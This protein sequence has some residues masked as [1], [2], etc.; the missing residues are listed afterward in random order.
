MQISKINAKSLSW[1]QYTEI[2]DNSLTFEGVCALLRLEAMTPLTMERWVGWK[3]TQF[4]G[5]SVRR[6]FVEQNAEII[7]TF[8]PRTKRGKWW[9]GKC[10]I[11]KTICIWVNSI[12]IQS[13]TKPSLCRHGGVISVDYIS[14]SL[15]RWKKRV[16]TG[17]AG[18][19][20]TNLDFGHG[21]C[22]P[23]LVGY[24]SSFREE[25]SS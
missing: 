12:L 4:Y 14:T 5:V 13:H 18:N 7:L 2:P 9:R 22:F 11:T 21:T 20:N 19:W 8:T 25:L 16:I 1:K 6:A 10:I 24:L 15:W 3:T 23:H 17:P